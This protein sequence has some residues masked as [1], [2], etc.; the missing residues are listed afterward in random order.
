MAKKIRLLFDANPLIGNKSGVGIYSQTIIEN[1]ARFHGSEYEI[2]GFYFNFLNLKEKILPNIPGVRYK[3]VWLVP[4][5]LLSLLRRLNLP[6]PPIEFFYPGSVWYDVLFYPNFIALPSVTRK[7]IISVVHDLAFM[8][9]PE[10]ISGPNL[11][12]LQTYIKRSLARSRLVGAVSEFSK[13]RLVSHFST[14]NK[15]F[16]VLSNGTPGE[17]AASRAGIKSDGSILFVGT[18]EPRKN[19]INL[20]LGYAKLPR[21]FQKD[22]PLVLA[23]GKGWQD[24]D[25]IQTLQRLQAEGNNIITL[26]YV[27]ASEKRDAYQKA[28]LTIFLSH[29][30][31][32]GLPILEAAFYKKPI[33][34]SDIPV[35]HEV[36]GDS[37]YYCDQNSADEIAKAITAVFKVKKLAYP[38]YTKL[39]QRYSW[40]DIA[41]RL[42]GAL[43]EVMR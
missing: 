4:G 30:E 17:L 12:F 5:V 1:L 34:L 18:L 27:S 28:S 9:H 40:R 21:S 25:I 41:D 10:Y 3:K 39:E 20:L 14:F 7:P 36:A 43:E 38:S 13:A 33:L 11:H 32:F 19:I 26:G 37:A 22:H 35:F 23:G 16:F 29:Y 8:D 24:G 15:K 2:T 31:G 42:A 6:Q